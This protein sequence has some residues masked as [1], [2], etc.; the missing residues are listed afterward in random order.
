MNDNTLNLALALSAVPGAEVSED[1]ETSKTLIDLSNVNL[2]LNIREVLIALRENAVTSK[3]A[4]IV[5]PEN[6]EYSFQLFGLVRD[7]APNLEA[8]Y[9]VVQNVESVDPLTKDEEVKFNIAVKKAYNKPLTLKERFIDF[10]ESR[11]RK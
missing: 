6:S 9:S 7:Y 5:I 10:I 3:P 1:F 8:R 2:D 11:K 4:I